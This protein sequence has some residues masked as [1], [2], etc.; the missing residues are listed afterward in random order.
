MSDPFG[1][2]FLSSVKYGLSCILLPED[3]SFATAFIEEAMFFFPS[4][5]YFSSVFGISVNLI[6]L[7]YTDPILF[8]SPLTYSISFSDSSLMECMFPWLRVT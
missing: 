1:V 5:V 6:W 8:L 2:D 3:S 7:S 4:S